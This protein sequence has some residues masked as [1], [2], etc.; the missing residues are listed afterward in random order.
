LALR[1]WKGVSDTA[2]AAC[3]DG[4]MA[5]AVRERECV[6]APLPPCV[7]LVGQAG[8]LPTELRE[9]RKESSYES[10]CSFTASRLCLQ[11]QLPSEI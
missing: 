11:R 9:S 7:P 5:A 6:A 10:R 3:S 8:E 2:P 4:S 1:Q